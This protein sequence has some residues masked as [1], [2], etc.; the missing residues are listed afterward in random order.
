MFHTHTHPE[1]HLFHCLLCLAP[2]VPSGCQ[3]LCQPWDQSEKQVS[4]YIYIYIYIYLCTYHIY[5]I[6]IRN[7]SNLP[8]VFIYIYMWKC[9][10][11]WICISTCICSCRCIYSFNLSIN[12]L[13]NATPS[14]RVP[15]FRSGF[16]ARQKI[17]HHSQ[18][19]RLKPNSHCR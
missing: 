4:I 11:I 7:R 18:T 13:G 6:I 17:A 1:V 3:F 10:C 5:S 16:K 14:S 2:M 15:G 9:I 12:Q 8:H 19:Q